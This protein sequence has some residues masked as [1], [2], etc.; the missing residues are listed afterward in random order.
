MAPQVDPE[1]AAALARLPP[2]SLDLEAMRRAHLESTAIVSGEGP[3]VARQVDH[4]IPG[5]EGLVPVRLYAPEEGEEPPGLVVYLHGGG[6]LMGSRASYEP[7]CRAL[8]AASGQAVLFVEYRLAPEDPFPASLEDSW[9]AVQWAGEHAGELGADPARL[10]VAGDSAGANLAAV[11]A[12]RARDA[13]GPAVAFQLLVYPA[14]DARAEA[15]SYAEFAD[16]PGLTA[17]G[18]RACWHAYVGDGDREDPDVSPAAA[19][20]L[21]G[22][23]PALVITAEI[24]PLR[25]EGE[26]YARRLAEAGVPVQQRRVSG[27]PHG[28][29]R[30]GGVSELARDTM[31]Q[32]GEAVRRGL[33]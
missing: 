2:P 25:D 11:C 13:G 8:C 15:P 23:P 26:H 9:A 7:T 3:A 18:M 10:A 28:F 24:D 33:A 12:R 1:I 22:L 14:T 16:G 32:A 21:A 20:D 27:A 30:Y 17:D 31:R 29:W 19:G 6:W 5:P 4:A